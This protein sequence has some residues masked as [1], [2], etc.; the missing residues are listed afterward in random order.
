VCSIN[1]IND[2][3]SV[4]Y[5]VYNDILNIPFCL[6][7]MAN[8]MAINV[9]FCNDINIQYIIINASCNGYWKLMSQWLLLL[10]QWPVQYHDTSTCNAYWYSCVCNDRI[11][12]LLTNVANGQY[13]QY[14]QYSIGYS[15]ASCVQ[16]VQ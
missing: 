10:L 11:V 6:F 14:L 16:P 15:V 4:W 1:D 7:S 3:Y 9:L 2:Q 13:L 8:T 5:C 12:W